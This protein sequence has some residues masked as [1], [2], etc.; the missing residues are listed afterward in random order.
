[1]VPERFTVCGGPAVVDGLDR[2]VSEIARA[3]RETA[4]TAA[5]H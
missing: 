4:T 3:E 2:I 5:A 1:V